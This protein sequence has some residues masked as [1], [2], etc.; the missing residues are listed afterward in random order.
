MKFST[1]HLIKWGIPGW[2]WILYLLATLFTFRQEKIMNLLTS[3]NNILGNALLFTV[4][5]ILI[6][7]FIYLI[8]FVIE[9]VTGGNKEIK[10]TLDILKKNDIKLPDN[11][12]EIYYYVEYLWQSNLIKLDE[13]KMNYIANRYSH[14]LSKKHELGSIWVSAIWCTPFSFYFIFPNW[15]GFI[16]LGPIFFNFFFYLLAHRSYRYYS[17]NV[18]HF[19]GNMFNEMLNK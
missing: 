10:Y 1:K 5:G 14:M 16:S 7:Y 8:Y 19:M 15:E 4:A 17:R 6:G 2:I 9:W 13:Y 12:G 3:Y 11:Q 18:D